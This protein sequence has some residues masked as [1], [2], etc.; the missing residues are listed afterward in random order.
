MADA[1]EGQTFRRDMAHAVVDRHPAGGRIVEDVGLLFLIVA[2]VIER[3]RA[4][5]GIDAVDDVGDIAIGL[6]SASGATC[7]F[8]QPRRD[9]APCFSSNHW[10][11]P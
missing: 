6:L 11:A 7:S 10:L 5:P 9:L 1:A 3:E 4:R 2:E 8:H